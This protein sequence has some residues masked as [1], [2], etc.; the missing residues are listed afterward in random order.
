V[1]N[2]NTEVYRNKLRQQLQDE[3]TFVKIAEVDVITK[4]VS[5][6]KMTVL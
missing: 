3:A 5:N 6:F 4:T 1:E 2:V